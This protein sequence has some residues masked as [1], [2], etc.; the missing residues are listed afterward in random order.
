MEARLC[1]S[2]GIADHSFHLSMDH[3]L[4]IAQPAATSREPHHR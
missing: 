2:L 4:V 3:W 1:G